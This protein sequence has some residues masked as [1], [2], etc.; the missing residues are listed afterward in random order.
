MI[1][2][3]LF[4]KYHKIC[5]TP[6]KLSRNFENVFTLRSCFSFSQ[7]PFAK[8]RLSKIIWYTS[9]PVSIIVSY[10]LKIRKNFRLPTQFLY[11]FLIDIHSA[12]N[13]CQ[14]SSKAACTCGNPVQSSGSFINCGG[15]AS[16]RCCNFSH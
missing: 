5:K 6:S 7:N 15:N 4:R 2:T 16:N 3:I 13:I 12:C 11:Y 1:N 9:S 14:I 8:I 10:V